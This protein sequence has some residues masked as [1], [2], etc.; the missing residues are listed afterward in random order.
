MTQPQNPSANPPSDTAAA[1]GFCSACG[2]RLDRAARFCHHCGTPVG[3]DGALAAQPAGA[4]TGPPGVLV[5]GV[6]AL[7][8]IAVIVLIAMQSGRDTPVQG[9]MPLG[10]GAMRAPD[11]SSM[12][13]SEQADRLFN[14]VMTLASEGK[15]D[16]AQFFAPMAIGA[17]EALVPLTAHTRYD[18]GLVALVSGMLGVA[19]AQ[20]D[21]ILAERPTHLLGLAL[22]ARAAEARGNA[23]EG[24]QFRQ[25]LVAAEAS[26]RAA[27]LPEYADHDSDIRAAVDLARGR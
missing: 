26:E 16:S 25:R 2:T 24:A 27:G 14:R 5:W 18:M 9:T 10:G 7:A 6:P 11:I 8:L 12:S 15:T 21:T 4:R 13:P 22:A 3:P 19:S 1:R 23:Q 20:A 17:F